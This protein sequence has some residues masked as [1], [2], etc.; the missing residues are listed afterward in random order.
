M[1][2]LAFYTFGTLKGPLGSQEVS[3]F[4]AMI[5]SV[6]GEARGSDG[7]IADAFTAK[8]DPTCPSFGQAFGLWGLFAAPRFYDGGTAPGEVTQA[9]T[10][11]LWRDIEAVRRF[12]YGGLHKAALAR[13]R[14]WGHEPEWPTY[15]MWWVADEEVPTWADACRR[16]ETLHDL[17]PT[18][19]AFGFG[20][21]FDPEGHPLRQH[22]ATEARP[23]PV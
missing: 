8:P 23:A 22:V 7:F 10:L 17:G 5:P 16:L 20:T 9:S 13:R 2:R 19:A 12:A 6:F 4:E 11:T 15:A 14:E 21:T 3:G 18:P 1:A